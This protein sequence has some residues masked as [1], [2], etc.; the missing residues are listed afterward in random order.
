MGKN[1]IRSQFFSKKFSN[2]NYSAVSEKKE[3][4]SPPDYHD[5]NMKKLKQSMQDL[6]E[7]FCSNQSD[8][9]NGLVNKKKLK[10]NSVSFQI[11]NN[12]HKT[13]KNQLANENVK[14]EKDLEDLNDSAYDN[15]IH[16]SQADISIDDQ[17]QYEDL[18][19]DIVD[20]TDSDYDE[21]LN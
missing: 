6:L 8:D 12:Q 3:E 21:T 10:R 19:V 2:E 5:S 17:Y 15:Q 9:E 11:D 4:S 14:E 13:L 18:D 20:K 1:S 16:K 7:D